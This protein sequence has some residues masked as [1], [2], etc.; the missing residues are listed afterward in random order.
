MSLVLDSQW[1]PHPVSTSPATSPSCKTWNTLAQHYF[2][3]PFKPSSSPW[4]P[5][6]FF[7]FF[8]PRQTACGILE[9]LNLYPLALAAQ[10]LNRWTTREVPQFVFY[11]CVIFSSFCPLRVTFYHVLSSVL[12]S[13]GTKKC[14]TKVYKIFYLRVCTFF[15]PRKYRTAIIFC[16]NFITQAGQRTHNNL[17]PSGILLTPMA[18]TINF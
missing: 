1:T 15:W 3:V 2:K 6:P 11:C 16:K 10:S 5:F 13:F 9:V 7:F 12:F 8:W 4:L 17:T 14:K 18:A